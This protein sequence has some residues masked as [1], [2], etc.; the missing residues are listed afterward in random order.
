M[1]SEQFHKLTLGN[2]PRELA[3]KLLPFLNNNSLILDCGCG[4]G[5][6][7]FLF[8]SQGHKIIALD[9]K[10]NIIADR[11]KDLNDIGN[12][13]TI[14]EADIINFKIPKVDCFYSSLTLSFLPRK[15]FYNTWNKIV[16]KLDREAIIAINI[17]GNR[18]EWY[19]DTEDM[20]FMNEVEFRNLIADL[21][22]LHFYENEKLGTCMGKDGLPMDKKWHIFECIVKI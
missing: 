5:N 16:A 6:D 18:D 9:K 3:K 7:T 12:K 17:F 2:P 14:K 8:V 22:V 21:N 1:S 10:T 4:A 15:D 20:T 13:I 11:I 19:Q